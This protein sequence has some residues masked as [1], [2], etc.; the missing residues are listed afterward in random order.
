MKLPIIPFYVL[1]FLIRAF[2]G[3]SRLLRAT[4]RPKPSSKQLVEGELLRLTTFS[5]LLGVMTVQPAAQQTS[6]TS[7][8]SF[9]LRTSERQITLKPTAGPNNVGNCMLVY[10]DGRLHLELRRQEFFYGPASLVTYEGKLSTHE[11]T[12]LRSI[13]DSDAVKDLPVEH[14]PSGPMN[15]DLF[16]WFTAEIRRL[17][18]VQTVGTGTWEGTGPRNSKDDEAWQHARVVLQPLI[19]WSHRIKSDHPPELRRVPNSDLVCGQ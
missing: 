16:G 10:P 19:D 7:S 11:L 15:P 17:T 12:F 13:L 3:R 2:R 9:L 1:H 4:I 5:L 6:T 14:Q 18:A 8:E